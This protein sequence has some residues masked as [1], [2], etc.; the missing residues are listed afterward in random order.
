MVTVINCVDFDA[1]VDRGVYQDGLIH[2]SQLSHK[3]TTDAR[4]VVRAGQVVRVKVVEVDVARKRIAL[5]MKLDA[6]PVRAS[7]DR[8]ERG[9]Q[10]SRDSMNLTHTYRPEQ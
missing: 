8:N 5:T 7:G 9:T 10:D 6:A 3:F 1:F 2:V 4:V